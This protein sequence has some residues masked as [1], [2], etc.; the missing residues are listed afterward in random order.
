MQGPGQ[1]R[2]QV[3]GWAQ[4]ER[5]CSASTSLWLQLDF[6]F[7]GVSG[8]LVGDS[9]KQKYRTWG[10]PGGVGPTP[11]GRAQL[12]GGAGSFRKFPVIAGNCRQLPVQLWNGKCSRVGQF[13]VVRP[14]L[15][16]ASR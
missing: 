14:C 15:G 1:G 6:R 12:G 4:W 8:G 16:L 5:G 2:G 11:G 7:L 9:Q 3:C 13:G 10:L